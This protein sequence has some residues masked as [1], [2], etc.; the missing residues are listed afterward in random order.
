MTIITVV[1]FF[2]CN[3]NTAQ[4]SYCSGNDLVVMGKYP[5][6][7]YARHIAI[8]SDVTRYQQWKSDTPHH[9]RFLQHPLK[10]IDL[11][12]FS[13]T[14]NVIQQARNKTRTFP[15]QTKNS[16]VHK[17]CIFATNV[18]VYFEISDLMHD[19]EQLICFY[20]L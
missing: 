8:L 12:I 18:K 1:D 15:V 16:L 10:L 4:S 9:N 20:I 13:E 14:E 7:I 17:Q 11:N 19:T 3:N 2:G 6:R 5:V